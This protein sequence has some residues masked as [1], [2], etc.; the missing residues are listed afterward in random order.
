M[1]YTRLRWSVVRYD[2]RCFS[3]TFK[4]Q[5]SL[6]SINLFT[7]TKNPPRTWDDYSP[8]LLTDL[9]TLVTVGSHEVTVRSLLVLEHF[10][11]KKYVLL[12]ELGR[13]GIMVHLGVYPPVMCQRRVLD[14]KV[15]RGLN[16]DHAS[17]G[18]KMDSSQTLSSFFSSDGRRWSRTSRTLDYQTQAL[19]K[20]PLILLCW[21]HSRAK[22]MPK[23]ELITMQILNWP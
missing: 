13:N 6:Y 20:S 21:R 4:A 17:T 16:Y 12:N 11:G 1:E 19:E 9:R 22:S 5:A 8:S 14:Q 3:V 2:I 15:K 23:I 18:C 7:S 10:L